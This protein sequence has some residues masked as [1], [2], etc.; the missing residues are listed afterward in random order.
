MSSVL[1]INICWGVRFSEVL[2]LFIAIEIGWNPL[3]NVLI[4]SKLK[5]LVGGNLFSNLRVKHPHNLLIVYVESLFTEDLWYIFQFNVGAFWPLDMLIVYKH[6]EKLFR[7][8]VSQLKL[9]PFIEK[10]DGVGP[11]DNRPSTD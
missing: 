11:V 5:N 10:I 7:I 6:K 3:K 2:S 8:I 1:L 9:A 4:I